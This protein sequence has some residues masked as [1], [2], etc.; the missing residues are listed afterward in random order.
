LP[1]LRI[2]TTLGFV[3]KWATVTRVVGL[4]A[5]IGTVMDK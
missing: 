2:Y 5:M 1:S 3:S 4:L